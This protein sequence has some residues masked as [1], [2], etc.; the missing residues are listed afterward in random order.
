MMLASKY[1]EI[2][3]PEMRDFVYICDNAYTRAQILEMEQLM[4]EKLNFE[5]SLPTPWYASFSKY[6]NAAIMYICMYV[7]IYI[8]VLKRIWN[9]SFELFVPT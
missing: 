2:Y 7:C 4:L 1:E 9:R 3:P 6:L 5:L 8:Y